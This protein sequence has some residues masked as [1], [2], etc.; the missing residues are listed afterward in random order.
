MHEES[1]TPRYQREREPP[2]ERIRDKIDKDQ[3]DVHAHIDIEMVVELNTGI[4]HFLDPN[5]LLFIITKV[6]MF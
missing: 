3:K 4:C 5:L 2:T 6:R 1:D